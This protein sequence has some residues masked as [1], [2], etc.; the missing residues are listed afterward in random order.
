MYLEVRIRDYADKSV[1]IAF[2]FC[3][4]NDDCIEWGKVS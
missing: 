3:G 4:L 2:F 1:L